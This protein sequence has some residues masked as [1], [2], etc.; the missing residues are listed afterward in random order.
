M[1]EEI[2]YSSILS[3]MSVLRISTI[4]IADKNQLQHQASYKSG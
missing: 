2:G 3:I 1:V 4:A